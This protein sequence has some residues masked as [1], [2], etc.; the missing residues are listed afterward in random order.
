LHFRIPFAAYA[1][2]VRLP[3]APGFNDPPDAMTRAMTQAQKIYL[4]TQAQ[5]IYLMTQA[6][7]IYLKAQAQKICLKSWHGRAR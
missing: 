3:T 2:D 5:K 4:M 7:K 6:Q 1:G